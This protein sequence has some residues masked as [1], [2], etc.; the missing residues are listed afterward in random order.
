LSI[1]AWDYYILHFDINSVVISLWI[2]WTKP[3]QVVDWTV[4]KRWI[5]WRGKKVY[6]DFTSFPQSYP[7]GIK[8]ELWKNGKL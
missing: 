5:K 3:I 1:F 8:G 2:L 6:S 4:E 7:Q